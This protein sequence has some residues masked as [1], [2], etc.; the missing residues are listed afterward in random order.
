MTTTALKITRTISAARE[1]LFE[2]WLTPGALK[3]FVRPGPTITIPKAEVDARVGGSFLIVMQYGEQ[4]IEHRGEYRTID[5]YD[6]LAF[7]WVSEYAGK[8]SVVTLTFKELAPNKTE[9]TLEHT[10][11]PSDKERENHGKGWTGIVEALDSWA[12]AKQNQ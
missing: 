7:T 4:S 5:K 6:V 12:T 11:L 9:L 10:G 1:D 8:S 2:A 3:E